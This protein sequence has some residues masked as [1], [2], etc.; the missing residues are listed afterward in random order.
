MVIIIAVWSGLTVACAIAGAVQTCR[1]PVLAG[2]KIQHQEYVAYERALSIERM[3]WLAALIVGVVGA[4]FITI[5]GIILEV[6]N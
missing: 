2:S 6:V 4:C 3:L 1:R 5:V